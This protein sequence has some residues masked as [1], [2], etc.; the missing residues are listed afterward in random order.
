MRHVHAQRLHI[1]LLHAPEDLQRFLGWK[2]L[3]VTAAGHVIHALGEL[4]PDVLDLALLDVL[5][6][7]A[8]NHNAA[9]M[10]AHAL[11][12]LE[13]GVDESLVVSSQGRSCHGGCPC[14]RPLSGLVCVK[15]TKVLT[16]LSDTMRVP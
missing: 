5:G 10:V 6:P 12:R 16:S 8:V 4:H 2:K 7:G 13:D 14:R 1:V 11:Q 3:L 15:R 9:A